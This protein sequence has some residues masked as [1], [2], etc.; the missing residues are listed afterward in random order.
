MKVFLCICF[1]GLLLRPPLVDDSAKYVHELN[2][3]F[4]ILIT[5]P[6]KIK[7][8]TQYL[9]QRMTVVYAP[10]LL[11]LFSYQLVSLVVITTLF[12]A[13]TR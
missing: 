3:W 7:L 1:I 9:S 13:I 4:T 6:V 8:P 12:Y 2:R 10:S 5:T 11:E